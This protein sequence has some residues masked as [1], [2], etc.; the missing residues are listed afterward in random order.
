MV[1]PALNIK[2]MN[3]NFQRLGAAKVTIPE[4]MQAMIL[5]N[6]IPKEYEEVAQ[7]TLQ[8]MEQTK[9]MFNYI[10]DAILMEHS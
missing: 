10:Q 7:M 6:V 2:E 4:V 3:E 5:L 8:T 9:L 1:N